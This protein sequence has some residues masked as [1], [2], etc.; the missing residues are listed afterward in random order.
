MLLL[1]EMLASGYEAPLLA[2]KYFS[3]AFPKESRR[4]VKVLD[5]GA[6]TGL[7]ARGLCAERFRHIDALDASESMLT[8][9]RRNNLYDNYYCEFLSDRPLSC[10]EPDNYDGLTASGCFAR[11]HIPSKA[12]HEIIRIVKPS[13]IVVIVARAASPYKDTILPLMK[14]L[15]EEGKWKKLVDVTDGIF[16]LEDKAVVWK[17]QV[18]ERSKH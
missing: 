4:D 7:V 11:N 3:E 1:Q 14:H 13:G 10:F 17:Y 8:A 15:E 5:V 6:G 9:A 12:L 16:F 2:V 18:L